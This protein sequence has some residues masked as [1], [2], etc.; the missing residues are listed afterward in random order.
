MRTSDLLSIAIMAVQVTL[1]SQDKMIV[2][3]RL[4]S[5]KCNLSSNKKRVEEGA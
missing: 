3:G 1:T 2:H 4:A 5:N